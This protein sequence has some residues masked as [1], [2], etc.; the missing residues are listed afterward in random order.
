MCG[1]G[2]GFPGAIPPPPPLRRA[3]LARQGR[4]DPFG[5]AIAGAMLAGRQRQQPAVGAQFGAVLG[6]AAQ[7]QA[8]GRRV[9]RGDD[10]RQQGGRGMGK[11]WVCC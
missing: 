3:R 9:L 7:G 8:Q 11:E 2:G 10:D 4:A 6:G 5:E 1:P